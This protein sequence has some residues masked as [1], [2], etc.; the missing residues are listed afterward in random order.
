MDNN[1]E[2]YQ[3]D[4]EVHAAE[5]TEVTDV[6]TD[7][8]AKQSRDKKRTLLGNAFVKAFIFVIMVVSF[9]AAIGTG[10]L[11][12]YA[13]S[14][15]V[16]SNSGTEFVRQMMVDRIWQDYRQL[17]ELT[18]N[19]RDIGNVEELLCDDVQVRFVRINDSREV[20][21]NYDGTP[22]P[23]SYYIRASYGK[24]NNGDGEETF[25]QGSYVGSEEYEWQLFVYPG[26]K[27]YVVSDYYQI[28][29]LA[30]EIYRNR[31]LM[32]VVAAISGLLC[33]LCFVLLMKSA[34][35]HNGK[36]GVSPSW[37]NPIPLDLYAVVWG[38]SASAVL[39]LWDSIGYGVI[40]FLMGSIAFGTIELIWGTVFA[41]EFATRLKLGKFW[42]NTITF[43]ILKLIGRIIKKIIKLALTLLE[44][45]PYVFSPLVIFGVYCVLEGFAVVFILIMVF[46]GRIEALLLCWF[47]EKIIM[48]ALVS[49]YALTTAKICEA[50]EALAEGNL[51]YKLDT[52]KMILDLKAHGDNLN[53]IAKGINA[54]VEERMKSERLKTELITNVS[55]DIKTPLTS[56]INY[57]DLIANEPEGSENIKEYAEVLNRHSMRL[58]KLIDDLMEASK[59]ATGNLEVNLQS[60]EVGVMLAQ[61]I[62]EYDE[63][64]SEKGLTVIA[65]QP[66][67]AVKISGDSRHMW[68]IFDNLMNNIYK[69]AQENSRVYL[70]VEKEEEYVKIIF[71][72]MSKYEIDVSSEELMERFTRG[73]KSRHMDGNGLGLSIAS[74]LANLQNGTMEIVTDGDLFKVILRFPIL[75]N[76]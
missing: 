61:T 19:P 14:A 64:F 11:E 48:L 30:Q 50:G 57:S 15:G 46:D 49:V 40:E 12:V 42:E 8:C 20:F 59:A 62:G 28:Y 47:I 27:S 51:T 55:H 38:I 6:E 74:S 21:S 22:T 26:Q 63:K 54:A 56:I 16:D 2:M 1:E 34:G 70:T 43:R 66:D 75:E 69:Y 4:M 60:C 29:S 73:D 23:F 72:N 25:K 7:D 36:T 31:Y 3:R 39:A 45:M 52:S 65:K 18:I 33:L 44:H 76:D 58:K 9:V 41:M 53:S 32:I 17:R 5:V 24:I 37:L 67:E 13:R 35:H 10:L 68:R 71:R